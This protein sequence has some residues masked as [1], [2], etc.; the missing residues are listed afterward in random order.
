MATKQ[1]RKTRKNR[2]GRKNM[3]DAYKI[4]GTPAEITYSLA[5]LIYE[6]RYSRSDAEYMIAELLG[7]EFHYDGRDF[8]GYVEIYKSVNDDDEFEPDYDGALEILNNVETS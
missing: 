6:E 8:S 1:G 3:F 4:K 2:K 5:W 7:N